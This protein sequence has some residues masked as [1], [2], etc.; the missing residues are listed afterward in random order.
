VAKKH[1]TKFCAEPGCNNVIIG[2]KSKNQKYCY[3][4]MARKDNKRRPFTTI[5]T[6]DDPN[7]Y[8]VGK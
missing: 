7:S 4:C 8:E 2:K 5:D 1:R 6:S 3:Q